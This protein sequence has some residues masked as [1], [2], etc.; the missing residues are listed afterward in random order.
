[1]PTRQSVDKTEGRTTS[2]K[3]ARV[4]GR[5]R[6]KNK[7]K[8][9]EYLQDTSIFIFTHSHTYWEFRWGIKG[10]ST[11]AF[12]RPSS[13]PLHYWCYYWC[14]C[15]CRCWRCWRRCPGRRARPPRWAPPS[16]W[17]HPRASL[18][19]ARRLGPGAPRRFLRD[20]PW[21]GSPWAAELETRILHSPLRVTAR[22]PRWGRT[23]G[24]DGWEDTWL[25]VGGGG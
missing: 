1:M 23:P 25:S 7:K 4:V 3:S 10:A 16:S 15:C 22:P 24:W 13:S 20:P 17:G 2:P 5:G 12:Y 18:V 14:Y 6:K 9:T 11:H 8:G 21:R 19:A